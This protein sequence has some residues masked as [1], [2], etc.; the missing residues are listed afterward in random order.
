M[1]TKKKFIFALL[2]IIL[3]VVLVV[4]FLSLHDAAMLNSL[5][6]EVNAL[7]KLDVTKDRFNRKNVT[8]GDYKVVETAIKTYLD[9]YAV[10]LQETLQVSNDP[11][12]KSILSLDNYS[13]DGP[14]FV[15]SL[16]YLNNNKKTFNDN[17]EILLSDLEE[18]K[19][20]N[21]INEKT[22]KEYCIELYRE[23][24]L[25]ADMKDSFDETKK[26]LTLKKNKM[27]NIFDTS[28]AILNFLSTCRDYWKIED[29]KIQFL[30]VGLYNQYN[31]L[32]GKLSVSE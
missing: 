27:N 1:S 12:L 2:F 25:N 13:K 32:I 28:I 6:K 15:K 20:S 29:N 11:T 30:D 21:Y 14:D 9:D 16:E 19:I 24:M 3:D 8:T 17:I 26:L 4:T 7:S 23:L 18:E 10:L 22:D 5:K 31:E